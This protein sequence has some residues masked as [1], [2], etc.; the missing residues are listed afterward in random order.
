M[1][2]EVLLKS[3]LLKL[4]SILM[5]WPCLGHCEGAWPPRWWCPP[6]WCWSRPT[7]CLGHWD[8]TGQMWATPDH[9]PRDPYGLGLV[10]NSVLN[11]DHGLERRLEFPRTK[12]AYT[13]I[14]KR[15]RTLPNQYQFHKRA[16]QPMWSSEPTI[17]SIWPMI[18]FGPRK[19]PLSFPTHHQNWLLVWHLIPWAQTYRSPVSYE[20]FPK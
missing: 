4:W 1:N 14:K 7:P 5:S 19:Y 17:Q 12:R 16:I 10:E 8:G 9:P 15:W 11:K 18:T 6:P 2:T 3:V 20:R 13:L